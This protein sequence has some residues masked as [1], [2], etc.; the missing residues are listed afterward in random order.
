MTTQKQK[1]QML[2]YVADKMLQ[3]H[4]DRRPAKK[5]LVSG[6]ESSYIV[7]SPSKSIV[8]LV[9]QH[10]PGDRFRNV[11]RSIASS[12]QF[13][14]IAYV[15]FKDGK[16]FFRSAMDPS[17]GLENKRYKKDHGLS[18]KN[19]TNDQL[20][21]MIELRPEENA[22]F[23]VRNGWIQYYQP[24]SERLEEGIATFHF[25]PV[26]LDYSHIPHDQFQPTN[27]ESVRLKLWDKTAINT[28]NIKSEKNFLFPGS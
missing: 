26:I 9:D 18:L 20:R 27:T 16:T 24:Q 23:D 14:S 17:T 19:Y 8:F 21:Q 13:D 15:F 4:P 22:I 3:D 6:I 11:Y 12:G 28:G 10:Y 5:T 7:D 25:G 1:K 2:D